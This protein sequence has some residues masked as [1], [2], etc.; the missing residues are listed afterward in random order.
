MTAPSVPVEVPLAPIVRPNGKLYRPR[1][2]MC[3]AWAGDE[4]VEWW[5]R[6]VII[7]G[8]HDLD[9][10]REFAERMCAY[11]YGLEHAI[12]PVVGWWRDSYS[13]D[14]PAWVDD[15]VR[16]RAGISFTASEEPEAAS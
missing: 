2:V 9:R 5:A 7:L 3:Y 12:R 1:K 13:G 16:G 15:P 4:P 8:T 10:A 14:G 6:G 11:W